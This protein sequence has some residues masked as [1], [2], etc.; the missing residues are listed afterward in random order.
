MHAD[1]LQVPSTPIGSCGQSNA[2]NAVVHV[3][4]DAMIGPRGP[5]H[6]SLALSKLEPGSPLRTLQARSWAMSCRRMSTKKR[7]RRTSGCTRRCAPMWR[8]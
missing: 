3:W 5:A 8:I 2:T 7:L 1:D 4:Q 6:S